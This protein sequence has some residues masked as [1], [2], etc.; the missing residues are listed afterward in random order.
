MPWTYVFSNLKGEGIVG[1][2]HQKELQKTNQKVFRFEKVIKGKGDKWYV[3][4]KGYDYS[5]GLIKKTY[6]KW[7]NI[8]QK[9]NL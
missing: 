9:R 3:K 5:V 2:F 6:Y 1:T 4:W 7:M 8:F